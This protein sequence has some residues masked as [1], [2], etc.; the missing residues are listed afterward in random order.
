MLIL[1]RIFNGKVSQIRQAPI[2]VQN[3]VTYD[4]VIEVS[5]ADLKL[6]PGM[7]ANATIYTGHVSRA[8]RV[9][10]A[11]LRF[12]PRVKSAPVQ[13]PNAQSVYVLDAQGQP[14]AVQVKTGISDANHVEIT[15]GNLTEGREV[16]TGLVAQPGASGAQS[17]GR[18][19]TKKLGF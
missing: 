4:I 14:Q 7:T 6:F 18:V 19:S 3:V 8:L 9:S 5:N 12:R 17:Q 13:Q 16:V 1:G 2:N 11:A 10:K 15:G